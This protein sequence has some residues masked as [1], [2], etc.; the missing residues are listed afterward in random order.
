M[1]SICAI[2]HHNIHPNAT[3]IVKR[4]LCLQTQ[5]IL[6]SLK[7]NLIRVP[8]AAVSNQINVN[9]QT[10]RP[11]IDQTINVRKRFPMSCLHHESEVPPG[12][13]FTL[14]FIALLLANA[15]GNLCFYPSSI[16]RNFLLTSPSH[17]D[18]MHQLPVPFSRDIKRFY[19]RMS[20]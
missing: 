10:N 8:F 19:V 15:F 7:P 5:S 3:D 20:S 18:L 9:H 14:P 17:N 1:H 16:K 12:E 6:S 2:S 11:C 13:W 4:L